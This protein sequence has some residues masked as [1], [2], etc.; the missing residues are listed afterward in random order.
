MFVFETGFVD[1]RSFNVINF[2]DQ[3]G[4]IISI[5]D[6]ATHP[7]G[8]VFGAGVESVAVTTGEITI[9]TVTAGFSAGFAG[10][11]T[12]HLGVV[13]IAWVG[14]GL[15]TTNPTI[16]TDPTLVPQ[17]EMAFSDEYVTI[18]K[19]KEALRTSFDL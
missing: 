7:R 8:A 10:E 17:T 4:L 13:T 18:A 5:F 14:S 19:S 3:S 6:V 15:D 2:V 11:S 9:A 16:P 12:S 1:P